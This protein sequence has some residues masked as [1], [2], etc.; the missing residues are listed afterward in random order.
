MLTKVWLI[1]VMYTVQCYNELL[2]MTI[3][4][5]SQA[6]LPTGEGSLIIDE[7]KVVCIHVHV[8][9]QCT[10]WN[11]AIQV[12]MKLVWS[13][14]NQKFIGHAMSHEELTSLCDVY[15]TLSP[16]YRRQTSYF[17]QTLWRD[18][19]SDFDVISPH[20]SSDSPFSH[21]ALCRI[22]IDAIQQFHLSGFK[23]VAVVADG[24]PSNLKMI[25]EM[26]GARNGAYGCVQ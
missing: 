22:V 1:Q 2:C 7:V 24:A 13:S 16:D 23:T 14:R 21:D 20:Y 9:V 19:T 3:G 11:V 26:S 8:S 5:Q 17:L 12:R 15:K 18:F 4:S 10:R 6:T 25:K